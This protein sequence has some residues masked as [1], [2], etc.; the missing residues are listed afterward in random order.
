MAVTL[1]R[2]ESD[3]ANIANADDVR[4]FKYAG[5]GR[6][7]VVKGYLSE[8]DIIAS[9]N[10]F[11]IMSG[12]I[13]VDGWQVRLDA[14]GATIT[15]TNISGT[16]YYT[17]YV[18]VDL[19]L[20]ENKIAT[21]KATMDSYDFPTIDKGDDISVFTTG[22]ARLVLYQFTAVNGSVANVTRVF[23]FL[24][25][26]V[27]LSRK[28]LE[29]DHADNASNAV[30][31]DDGTFEPLIKNSKGELILS[32]GKVQQRK[33]LWSA[34]S[35][36]NILKNSISIS[37][38]IQNGDLI[39][40]KYQHLLNVSPKHEQFTCIESSSQ[41]SF[42]LNFVGVGSNLELTIMAALIKYD[43]ATKTFRLLDDLSTGINVDSQTMYIYEISKII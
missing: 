20:S 33:V 24:D 37:E 41:I 8:C 29:A 16:Q 2:K 40:I 4:A 38:P 11:Q 31:K 39:E 1:L 34:P 23:D 19:A 21:I 3:I 12:E 35:P 43:V 14:S 5:L 25:G 22:I 9:G 27:S 17:V 13:I 42:P 6:N 7:G 30:V 26:V 32:T 15:T 10:T 28:S 18:E 36:V